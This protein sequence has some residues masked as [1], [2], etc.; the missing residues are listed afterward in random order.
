[1]DKVKDLREQPIGSLTDQE[2][3]SRIAVAQDAVREVREE[4]KEL[5]DMITALYTELRSHAIPLNRY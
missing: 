4:A 5:S 3:K 1:M 2:I